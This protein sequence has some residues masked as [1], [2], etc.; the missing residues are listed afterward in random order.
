[1]LALHLTLHTDHV[2]TELWQML[3]GC[4][5]ALVQHFLVWMYYARILIPLFRYSVILLFH[6]FQYSATASCIFQYF[7]TAAKHEAFSQTKEANSLQLSF[8]TEVLP[9]NNLKIG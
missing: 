6:I 4:G 5:Y 3:I 8:K 2:T 7:A 1:M 9:S